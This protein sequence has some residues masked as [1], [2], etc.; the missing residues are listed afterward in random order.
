V[1]SGQ[2]DERE[3]CLG[4]RDGREEDEAGKRG[5]DRGR[6]ER[7]PFANGAPPD[8]VDEAD[9]RR[10][11]QHVDQLR[12]RGARAEELVR[13]GEEEGVAGRPERR[14][15]AVQV[16]VAATVGQGARR[17]VVAEGVVVGQRLPAGVRDP[18]QAQ[19]QR[20]AEDEGEKQ[21]VIAQRRSCR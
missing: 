20:A 17:E 4:Q 8:Q 2:D 9:R 11:K 16:D 3:R 10:A 1:R 18:G 13:E 7:R 12:C 21:G 14:W 19:D 5:D 6:D 15:R